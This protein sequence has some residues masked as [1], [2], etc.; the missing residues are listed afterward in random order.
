VHI[1]PDGKAIVYTRRWV[2]KVNDKWE[3]AIWI[4][5]ADGSAIASW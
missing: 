1:S 2:D 5:D 3:S 4:M